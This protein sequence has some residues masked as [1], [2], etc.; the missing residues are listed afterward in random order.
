MAAYI[1]YPENKS[2]HTFSVYINAPGLSFG[3]FFCGGGTISSEK[4]IAAYTIEGYSE[5]AYISMNEENVERL[6]IADGQ[7]RQVV[8]VDSNKPFALVLPGNA[9]TVTFYD[10][11]GKTVNFSEQLL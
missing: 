8:E 2:D 6:E 9:G 11:D 7:S 3:Y 4:S 10:V 5:K 1:S